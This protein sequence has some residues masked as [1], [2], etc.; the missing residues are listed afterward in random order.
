[1]SSSLNFNSLSTWEN[2]DYDS[3]IKR[4]S[5]DESDS[6]NLDAA[7]IS[8][9]IFQMVHDKQMRAQIFFNCEKL[10]LRNWKLYYAYNDVCQKDYTKFILCILNSDV[11]MMQAV[12][13][14]ETL[15]R[16]ECKHV[17]IL[18]S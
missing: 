4:L 3:A 8:I 1:M 7:Q 15:I 9:E 16:D 2:I 12:R 5:S 6:Y 11:A 14:N 13:E 17:E 10:G 18:H